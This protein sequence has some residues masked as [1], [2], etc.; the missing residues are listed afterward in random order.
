MKRSRCMLVVAILSALVLGASAEAAEIAGTWVG[1]TEVPDQ[2]ADQVTLVL[3]K[4]AGGTY[5]GTI[6]DTLGQIAPGTEIG[7]VKWENDTLT[8]AFKLT[9][10]SVVT[11]TVRFQAGKLDGSWTH[12][13]GA[14]GA[15]TFEKATGKK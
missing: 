8:C 15:I 1:K 4:A 12:E 7:G 13:E 6:V 3:K 2:G 11:M 5:T 9:D 14:T 10:G